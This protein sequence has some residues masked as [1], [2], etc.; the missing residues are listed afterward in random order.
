MNG[1]RKVKY[2]KHITTTLVFAV[3]IAIDFAQLAY[4]Q[5]QKINI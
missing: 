3:Y 2:A 5:K 4:Y 1:R